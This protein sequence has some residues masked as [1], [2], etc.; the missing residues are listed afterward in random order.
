VRPHRAN[1]R[2]SLAISRL[3]SLKEKSR[4]S[5]TRTCRA[6]PSERPGPASLEPGAPVRSTAALA[7]RR[8]AHHRPAPSRAVLVEDLL[9]GQQDPK[10]LQPFPDGHIY[11]HFMSMSSVLINIHTVCILSLSLRMS[12]V[13][14]APPTPYIAKHFWDNGRAE[15]EIEVILRTRPWRVALELLAVMTRNSLRILSRWGFGPNP[16]SSLSRAGPP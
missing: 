9:G 15:A 3:T 16:P 1:A 7:A 6:L 14:P 12:R 2:R 11:L 4:S 8:P 13:V 5:S 10:A